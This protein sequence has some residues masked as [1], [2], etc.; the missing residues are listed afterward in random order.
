MVGAYNDIPVTCDQQHLVVN[1]AGAGYDSQQIRD[2][3]LSSTSAYEDKST[4]SSQKHDTTANK[5]GS[6]SVY[7]NNSSLSL[8]LCWSSVRNA[9]LRIQRGF[10]VHQAKKFQLQRGLRSSSLY[11]LSGYS[12]TLIRSLGRRF[13]V[14]RVIRG[15]LFPTCAR[16][17][18][19]IHPH[20]QLA[21]TLYM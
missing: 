6:C 10:N 12:W 1:I 8:Q 20:V 21:Q 9:S 2:T 15:R 14:S 3:I 16:H 4:P 11:G 18:I 7:N 19:H 5:Y 17:R 13:T